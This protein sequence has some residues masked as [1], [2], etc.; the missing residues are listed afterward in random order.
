[1]FG[2]RS[3]GRPRVALLSPDG[4]HNGF[5]A[6]KVTVGVALGSPAKHLREEDAPEGASRMVG[7]RRK[8]KMAV[9]GFEADAVP[10]GVVRAAI[11]L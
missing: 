6:R 10:D 2:G 9:T 11:E 8:D 7:V 4:G 5:G 1:M 3:N